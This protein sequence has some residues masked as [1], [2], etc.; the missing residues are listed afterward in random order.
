MEMLNLN[1]GPVEVM[2]ERW[3]ERL[4]GLGRERE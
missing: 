2:R 4:R 1:I 3:D